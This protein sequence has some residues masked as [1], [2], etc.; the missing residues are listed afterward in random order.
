MDPTSP[1]VTQMTI[2]DFAAFCRG[3]AQA[4]AYTPDSKKTR[5]G[6]QEAISAKCIACEIALDG[7]EILDFGSRDAE[8]EEA[9]TDPRF[10]RLKMGYCARNGCESLFYNVTFSPHPNVSW[11]SLIPA[12]H[13]YSDVNKAAA[14][15]AKTRRA[16]FITKHKNLIRAAIAVVALIIVFIARQYYMGGTI[17]FI[18][19]PEEFQV[20]RGVEVPLR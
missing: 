1:Q 19:Q 2:P 3:I 17:P 12:A 6:V 4:V 7:K 11:T 10:E 20:D 13:H 8:V 14:E 5:S 15:L 9:G 18:R 16:Q